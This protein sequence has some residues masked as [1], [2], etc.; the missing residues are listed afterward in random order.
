M[1]NTPR[2]RKIH[3]MSKLWKNLK[4][5]KKKLKYTFEKLKHEIHTSLK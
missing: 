1:L 4:T 3:S 2:T 5:N